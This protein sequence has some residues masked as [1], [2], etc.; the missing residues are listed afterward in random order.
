MLCFT[1][2][3]DSRGMLIALE[4]AREI[5]F[6]IARIYYMYGMTSD[7]SR[8]NHANMRSRNVYIVLRGSCVIDVDNGDEYESFLL[9]SPAKG[10]YCEPRTWKV[11]HH[12]SEDCL[13]LALSDIYYDAGEYINDYE[14]FLQAVR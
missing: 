11:L 13:L 5:P 1:E 9:D 6:S 2:R 3:G 10:L 12:F 4:E 8:G 14:Q 7:L